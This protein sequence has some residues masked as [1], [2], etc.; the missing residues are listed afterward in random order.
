MWRK[1]RTG[2][3]KMAVKWLKKLQEAH[4]TLYQRAW[5]LNKLD[6]F[7]MVKWKGPIPTFPKCEKEHPHLIQDKDKKKKKEKKSKKDEIDKPSADQILIDLNEK[8][9]KKRKRSHEDTEETNTD[10]TIE[11][12]VGLEENL[13]KSKKQKLLC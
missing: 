5:E 10:T 3:K 8:S 4:P 11:S 13:K 9:N 1:T 6:E 2:R 12:V 7:E